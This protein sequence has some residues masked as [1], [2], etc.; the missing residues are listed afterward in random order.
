MADTAKKAR[1]GILGCG[2]IVKIR[3]APELAACRWAEPAGFYDFY[4]ERAEEY[5]AQ[6]G[7]R[8][9][10]DY[11]DMLADP[12]VDGVVVCTANNAHAAM[13]I[14]ALQA[15]K[16]VLCE[17]PMATTR[18]DAERILRVEKE[19]AGFFMAAHNQRFTLAHKT[20]KALLASGEMGKVLSFRCTLAH[21]G[22]ER[23]S[24]NRSNATWYFNKA[25]SGLGCVSDLGIHKCDVLMHI[26]GEPITSVG[27]IAG[28]RDKRDE[29]GKLAAIYDNAVCVLET[30]SGI[31]GTLSLSYTNYGGM[32]NTTVYYC[33][34]GV[35]RV[36]YHPDC[37][38]EVVMDGGQT[39]RYYDVPNPRSGVVDAFAEAIVTEKASPIAA[40][41][42][43]QAMKTV[44][45]IDE[46]ARSGSFVKIG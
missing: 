19:S 38:L 2:Q 13:S 43:F 45:A 27:A 16:Y 30:A 40:A 46:A 1:I 37:A 14:E 34:K 26:L 31:M 41:Q 29:S 36:Q 28:T 9:Y 42:A 7:G 39:T 8:A 24:V 33:E 21:P 4:P 22:P 15:G 6:Y 32:E 10:A 20:A 17:K 18:E 25:A 5:A 12:T 23:F 11:H 44:F 35:L 3:H